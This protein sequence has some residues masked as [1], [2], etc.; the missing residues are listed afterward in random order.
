MLAG[1]D[2]L[3]YVDRFPPEA[4]SI[5]V[6]TAIDPHTGAR[7]AEG[8]ILTDQGGE[9]EPFVG[10][11]RDGIIDRIDD[12]L[13]LAYPSGPHDIDIA[14]FAELWPENKPIDVVVV[15]G[16]QRWVVPIVPSPIAASLYS[17]NP[18]P[19]SGPAGGVV[20]TTWIG[21]SI[22]ADSNYGTP[23][24]QVI[25]DL[26]ADGTGDWYRLQDGWGIVAVDTTGVLVSRWTGADV[27]LAW[28]FEVPA[29]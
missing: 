16:G 19:F 10:A 17:G 24:V 9:S 13:V 21:P 25:V 8:Q 4:G 11:G 3:L 26:R 15:C 2:G 27:E 14:D 23:S 1:P 7:V 18:Y 20:F 22:G 6:V 5:R 12:S 28:L 29:D